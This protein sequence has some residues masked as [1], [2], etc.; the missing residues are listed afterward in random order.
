MNISDFFKANGMTPSSNVKNT[1]HGHENKC[2]AINSNKTKH[3]WNFE[4][5][6]HY[7]NSDE[8]EHE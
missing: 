8:I 2:D 4:G 1:S 6:I 7:M 5:L 3:H